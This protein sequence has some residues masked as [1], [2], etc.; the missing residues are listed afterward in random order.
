VPDGAAVAGRVVTVSGWLEHWLATRVRQRASTLRGYRSHVRVYLTP[1]LGRI[2]LAELT[3]GQVQAMFTALGRELGSG[4]GPGTAASLARIRATLRAALNAALRL[5]LIA[6]NPACRVELPPA[7]RPRAVVWTASRIE[8]W[9]RTGIRPPVAVWTA[10]QTAQFLHAISGH[11]LYA[12]YHLIAL[13]GLRRGEAAGL[14]W[15]DVDLDGGVATINQQLQQYDGRMVVGPP[16]TAGSVRA[17]ALDRTTVAA[18]RRH[19]QQ[20]AME[21]LE[22]GGSYQ[23]SGYVFTG[24]HGDPLAPDRLTRTFR[25]LTVATGMPPVRLHDLRHGAAALV[26]AAGVD[27]RVVQDMLGHCS[28]VLTADT[29]TSVLPD[30]ARKAAEQ[31]AAL[32]VRAGRLVP[33]TKR[34][35]QPVRQP[36]RPRPVPATAGTRSR[37]HPAR[38]VRRPNRATGLP[39]AA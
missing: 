23:D 33:G 2:P 1:C 26:L 19:R 32:V 28:I 27:L 25:E 10:G 29:Y 9:R 8:E 16:K 11:R 6:V 36:R 5:G 20:Q 37:V 18:L 7:P 13:R 38:Q 12:A 30:V 35:R 22:V 3:V 15:C 34:T 4:G 17:I 31:V 14:R 24:L 21:R 39:N